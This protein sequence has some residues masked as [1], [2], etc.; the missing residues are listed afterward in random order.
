MVAEII[1]SVLLVIL[2]VAVLGFVYM[3]LLYIIADMTNP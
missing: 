3:W 2:I 1:T